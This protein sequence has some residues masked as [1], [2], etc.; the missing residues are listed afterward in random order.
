[1][2]DVVG[3]DDSPFQVLPVDLSIAAALTSEI[4][5]RIPEMPDR[6]IAASA[7]VFGVPLVTKDR[8]IHDSGLPVVW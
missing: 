4:C 5:Q 6:I 1:M 8:V 3:A 2:L 7:L